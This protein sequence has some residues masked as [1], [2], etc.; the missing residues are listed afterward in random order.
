[1][2]K[3]TMSLVCLLLLCALL[4]TVPAAAQDP[5]PNVSWQ[6]RLALFNV[7]GSC[8]CNDEFT[9]PSTWGDSCSFR[10]V[11][12]KLFGTWVGGGQWTDLDWDEGVL[13]ATLKVTNGFMNH[14]PNPGHITEMMMLT[15]EA[16][17]YIG[18]TL[19]GTYGFVLTL[20]D[21]RYVNEPIPPP[22]NN[23]DWIGLELYAA[24]KSSYYQSGHP[25]LTSGDIA[26]WWYPAYPP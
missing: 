2:K 5:V 15:G 4:S 12:G 3:R 21:S 18:S 7:H 6:P 14:D 1:M 11:G 26:L 19:K 10:A 22:E 13:E 20:A 9:P 16:T 25:R 8:V 24:D 23:R 17:V